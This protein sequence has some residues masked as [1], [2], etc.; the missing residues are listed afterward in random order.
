ME[1]DIHCGIYKLVYST[2]EKMSRN[3]NYSK[4]PRQE[5]RPTSLLA[6]VIIMGKNKDAIDEFNLDQSPVESNATSKQFFTASQVFNFT[7]ETSLMNNMKYA[8]HRVSLDTAKKLKV[9]AIFVSVITILA[10]GALA[11]V[12]LIF[13]TRENSN[14]AFAFALESFLDCLSSA[15]VIWRYFG[16]NT[17]LYSSKKEKKACITLG[18]FFFILAILITAKALSSLIGAKS[19]S[20]STMI[21]YL[22][23]G[24][25]LFCLLLTVIKGYIAWA[26]E[27]VS[28]GTDA[29]NSGIG[30]FLG[31]SGVISSVIYSA[32][33]DIWFV[34][35]LVGILC[36]LVLV[37]YGTW[38]IIY[39]LKISKHEDAYGNQPALED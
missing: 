1:L 6:G 2:I 22:Q 25:G 11:I 16:A 10:L 20:D 36:S 26:L 19:P 29:V 28:V 14:T 31:I 12:N 39:E 7:E 21:L 23:L 34:D 13:S 33:S 9:A 18:V 27:S 5:L 4:A 30:F 17:S 35:S 8:H 32:N 38:V 24:S 3:Y 15:V 37:S